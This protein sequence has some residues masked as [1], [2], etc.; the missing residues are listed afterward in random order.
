MPDR[1][2]NEGEVLHARQRHVGHARNTGRRS[3]I[4]VVVDE[5]VAGHAERKDVDAGAAHDL[6]GAQ[7]D[8]DEGVDQPEER[9]GRGADHQAAHPRAGQVR[10][11]DAEEGADQHH[12]LEPDVD[13]PAALG[14]D[15]AHRGEDEG[16]GEAEHPGRQRRPHEHLVEVV[17]AGLH[18]DHGL[19][20]SEHRDAD[21]NPP[22]SPL[23]LAR[24]VDPGRHARRGEQERHHRRPDHDRRQRQVS[25]DDA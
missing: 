5:H 21:G 14:Q 12:A 11:V 24:G 23:A 22:E 8:G 4:S 18:G 19:D 25:G 2:T 6:V 15:S 3:L 9:A 10:A 1:A 20:G 7:L 13:D 16:G 17:L